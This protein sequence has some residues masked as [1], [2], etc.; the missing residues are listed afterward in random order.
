MNYSDYEHLLFDLNDF[1]VMLVT[2]N[3]P[4]VMNAANARLHWELSKVWGTL[5][6]DD[7]VKVI[8]ITGAG[9]RAFSAG[10]DFS[11][12]ENIVGN[13]DYILKQRNEAADIVYNILGT[14]KPI[15]SAINGDA[16]GAGLAVA[17]MA[18]IP[19]IAEEAKIGDGH[20]KLGVAAGDHAC[21]IWPLLCG[22]AKAKYYLMTADMMTGKEAERLN[23][24]AKCLPRAEVLPEA[25]R[26]ARKLARG[27]QPAI[28]GTKKAL[29]GW[30]R[31]AGP[32]FDHSLNLEMMDFMGSDAAEGLASVR[33]KRRPNFPSAK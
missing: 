24:V 30:M 33:E 8:V 19:I 20:V 23:M 1:G 25:M 10:A 31:M 6:D 15:I 17:M 13:A 14:E 21:I 27:S 7:N 18:D 3:R 29:N 2:I 11:W 32:I 16:V 4:E 28:K 12:I 5:Q 26:I 22:M 9:D